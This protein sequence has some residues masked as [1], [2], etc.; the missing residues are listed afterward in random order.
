MPY[1]TKF[2]KTP[3]SGNS[4]NNLSNDHL[5]SL[6]TSVLISITFLPSVGLLRVPPAGTKL[7]DCDPG[8]SHFCYFK[9]GSI[10][11]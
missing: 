6:Q 3:M 10:T 7:L 5:D 1:L 2:E 8:L 9:P 4:H 11:S